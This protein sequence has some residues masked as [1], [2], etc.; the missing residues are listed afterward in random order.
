MSAIT[1][2]GYIV[3]N[4]FIDGGLASPALLAALW[5][6]GAMS[7]FCGRCVAVGRLGG[8][9]QAAGGEGKR[10]HSEPVRGAKREDQAAGA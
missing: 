3:V 2:A 7:V 8:G 4:E 1:I 5:C 10:A 9:E 6:S